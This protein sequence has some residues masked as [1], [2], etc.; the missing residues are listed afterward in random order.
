MLRQTSGLS[1]FETI[2]KGPASGRSASIAATLLSIPAA[3]RQALVAHRRYEGLR[4]KGAP[5][6]VAL[7]Q[8]LGLSQV[9]GEHRPHPRRCRHGHGRCT[10][11]PR[12]E[13]DAVQIGL[14]IYGG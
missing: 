5:H 13:R 8:A 4:S 9:G 3:W 11:Q 7:R 2:P 1:S 10:P 12:R 14:L 6:D